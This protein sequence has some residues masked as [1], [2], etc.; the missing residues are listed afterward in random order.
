MHREACQELHQLWVTHA[1][2]F[3]AGD[4]SDAGTEQVNLGL[5]V[6]TVSDKLMEMAA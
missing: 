2:W 5:P 3:Q 1:V 4:G 6:P